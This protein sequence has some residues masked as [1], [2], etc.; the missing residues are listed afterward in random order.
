[1]EW[2]A[3][4]M[5]DEVDIEGEERGTAN[6]T[7]LHYTSRDEHSTDIKRSRQTDRQTDS[8]Q[9]ECTRD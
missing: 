9:I 4:E 6:F 2:S 3:V 7:A 8:L 1:M 5:R